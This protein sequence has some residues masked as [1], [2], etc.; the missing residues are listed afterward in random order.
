LF[1]FGRLRTVEERK[2]TGSYGRR[3]AVNPVLINVW[4]LELSEGFPTTAH[5]SNRSVWF[6]LALSY[7]SKINGFLYLQRV[8][9][10][11]TKC[12]GM[13]PEGNSDLSFRCDS[14]LP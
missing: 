1:K 4:E 11:L 13:F 10:T 2:I 7:S 6:T 8:S 9:L 14:P 5:L 12:C 3:R